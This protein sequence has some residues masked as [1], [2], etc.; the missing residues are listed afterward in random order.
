MA[1]ITGFSIYWAQQN[2]PQLI[3]ALHISVGC[4]IPFMEAITVGE[5][6]GS[7]YRNVQGLAFS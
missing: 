3:W 4:L 7:E 6:I 5:C 2:I 1:I